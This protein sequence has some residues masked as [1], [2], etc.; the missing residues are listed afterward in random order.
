LVGMEWRYLPSNASTHTETPWPHFG[1]RRGAGGA[2]CVR[3]DVASRKEN[4]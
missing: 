3:I 4:V 2:P 1:I